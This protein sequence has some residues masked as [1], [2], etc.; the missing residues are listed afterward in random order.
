MSESS[1]FPTQPPPA[2]NYPTTIDRWRWLLAGVIAILGGYL[3]IQVATTGLGQIFVGYSDPS[4]TLL[5]IAE[6]VFAVAVTALGYFFAPGPLGRRI[7][8]KAVYV[9]GILLL[10]LV[11]WLRFTTGFGGIPLALSFGNPFFV[12]LLFGGLGWLIACAAAPMRYLVLLVALVALPLN[13]ILVMAGASSG[14]GL[15]VQ[16][17]VCGIAAAAILLVSRP[18]IPKPIIGI[19]EQPA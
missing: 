13:Y 19:A 2:P 18:P 1:V 3:T 10:A 5:V 14:F 6:L 16:Y 17:V 9:V 11:I 8:A 15:V 12:A 4:I 7:L